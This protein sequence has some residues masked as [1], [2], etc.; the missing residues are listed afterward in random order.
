MRPHDGSTMRP[1]SPAA[2][3]G[4][5]FALIVALIATLAAGTTAAGGAAHAAG[6]PGPDAPREA[7]RAHLDGHKRAIL[8][9][10]I[11]LLR[12]PNVASDRKN[13]LKNAALLETMLKKRGAVTRRLEAAGS[14]PVVYGAIAAPG[15][16]RTIV[17]YAHYDGQP[18][19]PSRWRSDPWRPEI[20]DPAAGPD[21]RPIA[22]DTPGAALDD[23]WRLYGRS[24]SDDKAPIVA[25]LA[26]LD[27]LR[28]A[29]IPP[30]VNLKIFL[31]GEEEAGS[32]H[33]REIL[34]RHAADLDADL[35]IFCDGPVHPS[36]RMQIYYGA[37][38]VIGLELT[39]YGATRVLHSGHYGNWAPNPIA[40]LADLLAVMRGPDGAIRIPGF[41]DEVR[42]P[43]RDERLA[44]ARVPDLGPALM[45]ELELAR[46]ERD[47]LQLEEAIM[48]PAINIRGIEAGNVGE[49]ARNA[50]PTEARASIDFRLVPDQRP[51]TIRARVEDHL[52]AQG[53]HIVR[54]E[55]DR[56][57]RL[58]YSRIVRLD[59][60]SGYPPY[61]TPLDLPVSRGVA[62]V[63]SEAAG[64]P[65]VELPTLGGSIPLF[66]FDEV[67]R[68]PA[69]GVPIVNHDNNQHAAD[70]NLRLRN[71]WDGIGI[72]AA[73]IARLGHVWPESQDAGR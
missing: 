7:V 48:R 12:I 5:S 33:L 65:V 66:I 60:E 55:P 8:K 61:R 38:G 19:D 32:G 53:F 70:E 62:R 26:A 35:W 56:A 6:D 9:E 51:E 15:A 50:I 52:R 57:A 47:G 31:E 46:T 25:I 20:R 14:P 18:V 4:A 16:A 37:R 2:R 28:A 30:S 73:L 23:A 36:R 1:P 10:L 69:I 67:L 11:D 72:Y 59:W 54:D 29:G 43:T 44:L 27:A 22:W 64:G 42:R 49:R 24:A 71:L 40:I 39:V 45:E 63:V 41:H 21:T 17:L 34:E 3:R 13:I 58:R 68:T